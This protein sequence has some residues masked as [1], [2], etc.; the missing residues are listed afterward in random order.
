[1]GSFV[2][3][4][5]TE[6]DLKVHISPKST[7]YIKGTSNVNTFIC[8]F[9]AAQLQDAKEIQYRKNGSS[10][11]LEGA[12]L[13]LQNTGFDCGNKGINKDFHQLLK[14]DQF[15]YIRLEVREITSAANSTKAMV[16]IE[17]ANSKKDY[18]VPVTSPSMASVYEGK[19]CVDIK[20]FD[21]TPPK[22]MMG[23]ITVHDEIEINFNLALA[24]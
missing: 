14:T 11:H 15:P 20:D 16:T 7:L 6:N 4:H 10:L 9:D 2:A 22:K 5:S 17:I 13:Q 23:L 21:L 18:V 24:F 1:M 19:L 3:N 12:I 8:A